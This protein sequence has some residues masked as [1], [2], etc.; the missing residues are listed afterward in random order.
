[1]DWGPILAGIGLLFLLAISQR[2][3]FLQAWR[4][5]GRVDRPA[6]R[7]L[8]RFAA[9]FVFGLLVV[10]L[11]LDFAPWRPGIR[12][13]S[14]RATALAGLWLLSALFSYL[15]LHV[16]TAIDWVWR[17]APPA[18]PRATTGTPP[19]EK[20]T[21]EQQPLNLAR[22]RFVHGATVLA[23]AIPFAAAAYGFGVERLRF[24]VHA[25]ELPISG[26]PG[27]LEGMRI[28]QLSDLHM[29]SYFFSAADARRAVDMANEFNADVVMVTGDFIT[30][31]G[32]PLETCIA[33]LSRLHAP[34]GVWGC[35][36]NHEIYARVEARAARLFE[37]Y[38]M[39]LL[40]QENVELVHHGQPFNLIGV[41]YQPT[42]FRP[43]GMLKKI[44]PLV[45]RDM[46]NILLSHN[47]NAFPRAA[48]LGI[49]LMLA[50]HTHGGQVR[51]EILNHTVSPALFFTRYVADLYR[52]P[53]GA[54]STLS[55][56][57]AWAGAA[58]NPAALVY[59][60]RGLGT[61]GA[62]VRLGVPPEITWFTL[63]R[64]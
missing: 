15:A 32:D 52:R 27:A 37:R 19:D 41:D 21:S 55:D 42:D 7:Y 22:R 26:L 16:V 64:A 59:V 13:R 28:A 60:N 25:V 50:G 43:S 4:L 11:F 6:L 31:G 23:G 51:V 5:G 24:Q 9:V 2:Y 45:Q 56:E 53:L 20:A 33:E 54:M 40:R 8:I 39:R 1:V 38:G 46:P 29:S 58:G 34:L 61:I 18:A 35:N 49:E 3:W 14:S 57:A 12:W 63:R 36:G 62:P 30:T 10:G 17:K 44:E 47:P 48:E